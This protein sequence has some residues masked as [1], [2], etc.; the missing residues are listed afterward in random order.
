MN[1][2]ALA[3]ARG[4]VVACG[5]TAAAQDFALAQQISLVDLSGASFTWLRHS[6]E[7][8]AAGLYIIQD[9]YRLHRFPVRWMRS[10]LRQ[11]LGTM[12]DLPFDEEYQG[13]DA[14]GFAQ[15]AVPLLDDLVHIVW[16]GS[17]MNCCL[18]SLR[19]LSFCLWPSM[20]SGVF[21][22]TH[23]S[24]LITRSGSGEQARAM[25]RSGA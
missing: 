17:A 11:M 25:R 8:A 1:H 6:I 16:D 2:S 14:L 21:L 15:A 9:R 4:I 7:S 13:T 23:G 19:P 22:G 18:V 10:R 3:A 20:T 12:P 24:T 5:F